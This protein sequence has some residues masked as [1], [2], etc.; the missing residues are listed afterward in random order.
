[1]WKDF[2]PYMMLPIVAGL[3]AKPS[4]KIKMHILSSLP[5]QKLMGEFD[6]D[7]FCSFSLLL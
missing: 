3:P 7:Y 4:A 5:E 1:M 2:D 6:L